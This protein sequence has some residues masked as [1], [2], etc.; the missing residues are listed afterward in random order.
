MRRCLRFALPLLLA[1]AACSGGG[2]GAPTGAGTPLFLGENDPVPPPRDNP[3][4]GRENPNGPSGGQSSSSGGQPAGGC[5]CAGNY[6]CSGV[7]ANGGPA[8]L[9][10]T[11]SGDTCTWSST[12]TPIQLACNGSVDAQGVHYTSSWSGSSIQLCI[13][14]G[15][16]QA[17]TC[18]TC[19]PG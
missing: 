3:G 6:M 18:I 16:A 17:P 19:S 2:S 7:G 11:P 9:T 15:D 4:P 12:G 10:V 5:P 8:P 13:S 1:I 14:V